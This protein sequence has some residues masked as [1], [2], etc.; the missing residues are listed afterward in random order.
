M[1]GRRRGAGIYSRQL[2][3]FFGM[4]GRPPYSTTAG[5]Q[6]PEILRPGDSV[7]KST[8]TPDNAGPGKATPIATCV[9]A[10][11]KPLAS[12]AAWNSCMLRFA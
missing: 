3:D 11:I 7:V 2:I 1:K 8:D 10:K 6:R 9:V 12:P 4:R 5:G